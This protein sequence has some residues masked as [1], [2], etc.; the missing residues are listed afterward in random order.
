R[1]PAQAIQAGQFRAD[2][3]F[4]LCVHR[5]SLPALRERRGDIAALSE[6][7]L[8]QLGKAGHRVSLRPTEAA[9]SELRNYGFPGNVRELRNVIEHSVAVARGTPIETQHLP[10]YLQKLPTVRPLPM[11]MPAVAPRAARAQTRAA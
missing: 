8:R 1:D 5:I 9:L 11:P 3:F 6:F 7:F 4:R 10:R 2:L